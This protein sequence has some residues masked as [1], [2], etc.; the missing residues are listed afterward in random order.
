MLLDSPSPLCSINDYDY[1]YIY[2]YCKRR[3][4]D[5]ACKF[6]AR[7]FTSIISIIGNCLSFTSLH[8][9]SNGKWQSVEA[10]P[11]NVHDRVNSGPL[12]SFTSLNM[13]AYRMNEQSSADTELANLCVASHLL[14][15]MGALLDSCGLSPQI[16]KN[17]TTCGDTNWI[18]LTAITRPSGPLSASGATGD[19]YLWRKLSFQAIF[20]ML[21]CEQ[22][23]TLV[24][25][26]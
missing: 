24:E 22:G 16:V 3:T 2:N 6:R 25:Q 13:F 20:P 23:S 12:D 5:C 10:Y 7:F 21:F 15:T 18:R 4:R 9:S 8:C 19:R 1:D 17:E 11:N 14:G 26:L